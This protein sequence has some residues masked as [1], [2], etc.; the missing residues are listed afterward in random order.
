MHPLSRYLRIVDGTASPRYLVARS[1]EV[2][3]PSS[4]GKQWEEH[5]EAMERARSL[6]NDTN[7]PVSPSLMDLK[8]SLARPHMNSCSLCPWRC[9][10]A[11]SSG[12]GRCGVTRPRLA[13]SFLHMGEEAPL[14]PSYTIFFAG[15]NLDCAFCQNYD[16]S[17]M[18]SRGTEWS[19]EELSGHLDEAVSSGRDIKNINWVGGDPVPALPYVLEVL[20]MMDANI[21]QI[22]NS[23]M[24]LEEES[25][26]LLDG[27]I[28]VYLTDLKFGN[29]DCA[30]RLCGALDYSSVVRQNHMIAASQG[31]V[32]VRH[33]QLPGHLECCTLPLLDWMAENLPGVALNLMDQYRPAY[34]ANEHPELRRG[35]TRKEY[36]AALEYARDNGLF[37]I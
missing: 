22:W 25:M 2:E 23:N 26:R 36:L 16:I 9:G 27:V 32:L 15:C 30:R 19:E 20:C 31:E 33:L 12:Q 17:N 8:A 6:I 14:I 29:D 35:L 11:R 1:V 5:D 21:A 34:R 37:L 3:L 4:Q 28:D 13:S 10:A 7:S 18:P 24:Y